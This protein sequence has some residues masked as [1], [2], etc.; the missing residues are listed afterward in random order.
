MKSI[1]VALFFFICSLAHA[2]EPTKPVSVVIGHNPGSGNELLFR[3][4]DTIIT[5]RYPQVKFVYDFRPGAYELIAMNHFSQQPADGHTLYVPGISIFV[6]TSFW[7]KNQLRQ[8][9]QEWE[10]VISIG[11]SPIVLATHVDNPVSNTQEF[12]QH[13]RSGKNIDVGTGAA[14]FALAY[15]IIARQ[16]GSATIQKIQYNVSADAMKAAAARD[17]LY[18]LGPMSAAA[19][20]V[21]AG[22]LRIV[23]VTGGNNKEYSNLATEFRGLDL[24]P[25]NGIVLPAGTPRAVLDWYRRVFQEA[26]ATTEYQEHLKT[27]GWY[28]SL[29]TPDA[30][31]Q[32]LATQRKKWQPISETIQFK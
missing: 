12:M 29:R 17:L 10:P 3:K 1:F 4:L 13:L 8:D 25:Q 15:E 5:Q 9:P 30:Y 11:E 2:W 27:T 28:D 24:V 21:K 6:G 20:L 16:S 22:K 14:T 23:A 18:A 31:R 26:M 32:F 19:P 7:F